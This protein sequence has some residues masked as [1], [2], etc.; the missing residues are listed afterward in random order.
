VAEARA[1]DAG[2]GHEVRAALAGPALRE[3]LAA[4]EAPRL[5]GHLPQHVGL[6]RL[7]V[8]VRLE[9]VEGLGELRADDVAPVR[10]DLGRHD[11]ALLDPAAGHE[12]LTPA[13]LGQAGL[14]E[15]VQEDRGDVG[16]LVVGLVVRRDLEQERL[17]GELEQGQREGLDL[18]GHLAD[19]RLEAGVVHRAGVDDV[20]ALDQ[21]VVDELVELGG[22]DVLAVLGH[23][24][25][26]VGQA[27]ALPQEPEARERHAV[28]AGVGGVLPL[29]VVVAVP[30]LVVH[31]ADV[32]DDGVVVGHRRL[33]HGL[34]AGADEADAG[35]G[36]LEEATR[37]DVV[38]VHVAAV[39]HRIRELGH[40]C[41]S[42]CAFE[43]HPVVDQNLRTWGPS[44][45]ENSWP[46]VDPRPFFYLRT[47][48]NCK[49]QFLDFVLS[50]SIVKGL[51]SSGLTGKSTGC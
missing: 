28:R 31:E 41:T 46:C 23:E 35:V 11:D 6:A 10:D 20:D 37:H 47:M 39:R 38:R 24:A 14:G 1:L 34:V 12:K 18:D 9:V 13:E 7:V 33:E 2:H 49:E 21:L 27:E 36:L 48:S 43:V 3:R 16:G 5:D 4:D 40:E 32:V 30:R 15:A 29:V 22:V 45:Q 8:G 25:L 44:V 42:V 50:Y 19:L 51:I 26:A 17:G